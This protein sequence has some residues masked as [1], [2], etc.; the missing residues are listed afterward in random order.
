MDEV[1]PN[2]RDPLIQGRMKSLFA[3]SFLILL[4]PLGS[5]FLLK[6][7]LFEGLFDYQ[8]RDSMLYSA[9]VAV[10]MVHVVLIFWIRAAWD[11][12]LKPDEKQD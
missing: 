10:V 7:F 9:I 4:V 8:S 11:E 1:I 12:G 2:L 5:M 3:Y 6:T